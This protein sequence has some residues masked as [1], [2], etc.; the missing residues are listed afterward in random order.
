MHLMVERVFKET[1]I[2]EM[3]LAYPE[4]NRFFL[5]KG[6]RCLQCGEPYWGSVESFLNEQGMDP[7]GMVRFIKELNAYLFGKKEAPPERPGKASSQ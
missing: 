4:A 5:E 6:M 7:A 1:Q 3:L 2:E